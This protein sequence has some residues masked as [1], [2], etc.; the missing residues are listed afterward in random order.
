MKN[1]INV[2]MHIDNGWRDIPCEL[3]DD[4]YKVV[5]D[6]DGMIDRQ[7]IFESNV[8]L[9]LVTEDDRTVSDSMGRIFEVTWQSDIWP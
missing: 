7:A 2:R 6:A 5:P 9:W 8:E 4:E 1:C 3:V